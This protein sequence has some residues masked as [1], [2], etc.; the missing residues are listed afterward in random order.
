ML[1]G[2]HIVTIMM[3]MGCGN[4]GKELTFGIEER[5][6]IMKLWTWQNPDLLIY[7]EGTKYD[8]LKCSTYLNDKYIAASERRRFLEVY[9][10]LWSILEGDQLLWCYTEE[11]EAVSGEALG[12]RDK[13]LWELDVPEEQI[14]M[15]CPI[16]WN[17]LVSS[18]P[19]TVLQFDSLWYTLI[20][21]VK[22]ISRDE[23]TNMFQSFWSSK[24]AGQLWDVLFLADSTACLKG[25]PTAIVMFPVK[26]ELVVRTHAAG[27][28][29]WC[30]GIGG[31]INEGQSAK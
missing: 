1:A 16:A 7:D 19:C 3:K 5:L 18:Q 13:K 15:I 11:S 12:Y 31:G 8:S 4:Q 29:D 23:F 9:K 20:K 28:E 10:K 22:H 14:H 6:V 30:N 2:I 17:W 24:E 26:K 25:C 21:M 27:K